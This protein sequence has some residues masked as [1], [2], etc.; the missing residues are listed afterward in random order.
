MKAWLR[1]EWRAPLAQWLPRSAV[2][3]N[4]AASGGTKCGGAES[5]NACSFDVFVSHQRSGAHG[6]SVVR[7]LHGDQRDGMT[8]FTP[9]AEMASISASK[10][11][12]NDSEYQRCA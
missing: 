5:E 9:G 3:D 8:L 10:I 12:G 2:A 6:A 11:D 4:W 1:A 7:P